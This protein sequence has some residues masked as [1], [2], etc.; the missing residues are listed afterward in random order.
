[1]KSIT[2]SAPAKVI[3]SGEHA[4][5][6]GKPAL[7][8]A[9]NKTL[10]VTISEH[11]NK[12]EKTLHHQIVDIVCNYLGISRT[13]H[14]QKHT[15]IETVSDIP[16]GRGLGSSAAFSTACSAGLMEYITDSRPEKEDIGKC[17]YLV[18]KI[19][20]TNPSGVDTASSCFGGLIYY[21]KE[22][23]FLKTISRL[24]MQIPS[25]WKDHLYLI[26][27]GKPKETT[28]EMVQSVR[29]LYNKRM[30]FTDKLLSQIEKTTKRMVLSCTKEDISFFK[31]TIQENQS[32]LDQLGVVSDSTRFLIR[33]LNK[34][35]VCKITGAGGKKN[36]S[37]YVLF[38]AD[39]NQAAEKI[40]QK[41]RISFFKFIPVHEGVTRI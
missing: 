26:D 1:M 39:D 25:A 19:F 17:A 14:I 2:Y 27:S 36:G 28:G 38:Y 9:I 7:A 6:Y 33:T 34:W 31:A 16:I 37:G 4:V 12:V 15:T 5:V 11:P 20:H 22:F 10:T 24:S 8:T 18:E 13:Q 21:R 40:M 23:E 32:Y 3:I 41:N 35:G 30:S 29:E